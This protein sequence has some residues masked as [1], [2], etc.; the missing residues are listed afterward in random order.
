MRRRWG[1]RRRCRRMRRCG[2]R[3]RRRR[4]RR[5]GT[6]RSGRRWWRRRR[7]R[8]R[9]SR[10]RR[11]SRWMRRLGSRGRRRPARGRGLGALRRFLGRLL[12]FAVG[13]DLARRLPG[14][15]HDDGRG[16]RKRG[17]ACNGRR[18]ERC[19]GKQ[20]ESNLGHAI[21][22]PGII[23]RRAKNNQRLG[24]IVA[25]FKCGFGFIFAAKCP[26]GPPFSWRVQIRVPGT[27]PVCRGTVADHGLLPLVTP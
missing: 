15:G 22:G 27:L 6:R 13:T 19:R 20:H 26:S 17:G 16:L 23:L 1:R 12:R 4:R 5:G 8:R 21:F 9:C 7:M 18:G 25:R 3:G 11:R 10:R 24:R 14:L 2:R